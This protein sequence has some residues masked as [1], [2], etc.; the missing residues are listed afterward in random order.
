MK[1]IL[2]FTSTTSPCLMSHVARCDIILNLDIFILLTF[3]TLHSLSPRL[4][5]IIIVVVLGRGVLF[6]LNCKDNHEP[7]QLLPSKILGKNSLTLDDND[8][9]YGMRTTKKGTTAE[10][11]QHK[12]TL[13]HRCVESAMESSSVCGVKKQKR[14]RIHKIDPNNTLHFNKQFKSH[15][16]MTLID[17]F[18]PNHHTYLS[19]LRDTEQNEMRGEAKRWRLICCYFV[20]LEPLSLS[21]TAD[22]FSRINEQ[23][24]RTTFDDNV[25]LWQF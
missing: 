11:S 25:R 7:H 19:R 3:V 14:E 22:E 20:F 18:T 10:K 24:I 5:I 16:D 21:S 8:E 13:Q 2:V 23:H 9:R 17:K 15:C 1:R 4:I 6:P 12:T